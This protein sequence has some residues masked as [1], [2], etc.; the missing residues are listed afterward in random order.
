MSPLTR[1][2][3]GPCQL[4]MPEMPWTLRHPFSARL[5]LEIAIYCTHARIHET[6]QLGFVGGFV[7]DLWVF[8]FGDRVRFL[9]LAIRNALNAGKNQRKTHY[10]LWREDT[11]LDLPHFA[12]WCRRVRELVTKHGERQGKQADGV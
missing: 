2:E 9:S 8:N 6:T 12:D 3:H 10:L 11:K 1:M 5:T 7:H 4:D